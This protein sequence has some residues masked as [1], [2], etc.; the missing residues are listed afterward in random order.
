M[1]KPLLITITGPTASGKSFLLDTLVKE[2]K[3]NKVISYTTR[4]PRVGEEEGKDYYFVDRKTFQDMEDAGKLIEKTE[5]NGTL[6]GT[7]FDEIDKKISG[8]LP[9]AIILEPHGV[10]EFKRISSSRSWKCK[11]VFVYVPLKLRTS[12]IVQRA[13]D[14]LRLT[15]DEN[16]QT[17]ILNRHFNRVMSFENEKIW[18]LME[19]WD[20]IVPGDNLQIAQSLIDHLY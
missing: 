15:I 18:I 17:K 5:Y 10:Q 16:I 8:K 14:E 12:R 2:G 11:N 9:G 6:Y 19:E 20:I 1:S 7:S 3:V 4:E 13:M